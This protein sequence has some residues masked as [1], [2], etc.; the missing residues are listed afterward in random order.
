MDK[1][2]YPFGPAFVKGG[3]EFS[4]YITG[5]KDVRIIIPELNLEKKLEKKTPNIYKIFISTDLKKIKY[6][7]LIDGVEVI[8][9]WSLS[10]SA[11]REWG[12]PLPLASVLK[13]ST[14]FNWE[15][16]KSPGYTPNE[17]IIYEMHV[18]GFTRHLKSVV[19]HPG[20][21]LGIIEKLPHLMDL[22]V[23]AIELLPLHEFNENDNPRINPFTKEKL[24]N[25]W[26]YD[27]LSFMSLMNRYGVND[28]DLEFKELVKACHR[29]GIEVIV[30]VVYNHVG[31]GKYSPYF[32]ASDNYFKANCNDSGC[33]HTLDSENE[34]VQALIMAS[35]KRLHQEFHVDGFRFD[36]ATILKPHLI[37]RITNDP[38]LKNVK[39]IAEPWD[40]FHYEGGS[41]YPNS[42]WREWS[43]QFRDAA[44]KFIRG[45]RGVKEAFKESLLSPD[46]VNFVT[47]HDGFSMRDLVSYDHK[48]NLPNG[49]D[50]RDGLEHNLSWNM[51]KEGPTDEPE[52][53]RLR[54]RQIKNFFLALLIAKGTPMITMGDEYGHTKVG[55]N[56]TWCQDNILSW[57]NWH[58]LST[59]LTLFKAVQ[60]LIRLRKS[61]GT[62]Y[63]ITFE[64]SENEHVLSFRIN[65]HYWVAF[66]AGKEPVYA[67][68]PDG[69]ESCLFHSFETRPKVEGGKVRMEPFTSVV[70]RVDSG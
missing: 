13:E 62:E 37:E 23:T 1:S 36:L 33:G 29:F 59:N 67:K 63:E 54:E 65:K 42:R 10:L 66:N 31:I 18:R 7:Y 26:G 43:D 22:G 55:N 27:A 58:E 5:N 49:E 30:D 64:E 19:D 46:K 61:L 14:P 11:S 6:N 32:L 50:N 45:D 40:I 69:D 16:I 4:I 44:R 12:V 3:V 9:P 8:D 39:L 53:M 60:A 25:F 68:L 35:L 17:L 21:F 20:T 2:P 70:Y 41:F 48:H 57:F 34:Q 24:Y 47:A 56:N 38:G 28:P 15:G 51:G 52:I